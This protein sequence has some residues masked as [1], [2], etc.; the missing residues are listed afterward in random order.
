L[1]R[2]FRVG[3]VL[4]LANENLR[5]ER[6][7]TG[8]GASVITGFGQ[9]LYFRAGVYCTEI[10]R[11]V[12]NVTLSVTPTLITRQR[13]NLGRT[14]SC[15]AEID[16]EIRPADHVRVSAGYL[17][18]N[19]RVVEFPADRELEDL[20]IPQVARHQFTIRTEYSDPKYA[21]AAVQVRAN[22][23]QFDDDRNLLPLRGFWTTDLYAARRL[24]RQAEL[25][26]AAENVFDA[27]IQ[28]GRTPVL[29][30]ASPRTFRLGLRLRFGKN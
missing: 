20:R 9:R 22:T 15:G 3:D 23:P 17:F 6:A 27:K 10:S 21:T 8:E 1:Y 7:T 2:G 28:S 14:R 4:T 24:G 16:T 29:T 13:Q 12:S 5:A 18:V 25:Y 26:F 19:S 30:L 11:S